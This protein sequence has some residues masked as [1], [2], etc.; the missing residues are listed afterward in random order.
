MVHLTDKPERGANKEQGPSAGVAP[1][2]TQGG[3][4]VSGESRALSVVPIPVVPSV[5]QGHEEPTS[6]P[7]LPLVSSL[8]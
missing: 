7:P 8:G 4:H 3:G 6:N 5:I 1:V 2:Q